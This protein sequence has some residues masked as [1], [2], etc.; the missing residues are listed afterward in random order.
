MNRKELIS[1]REYW[2]AKWQVDLFE[3]IKKYMTEKKLKRNSFAKE[4]NVT[5]GYISQVLNGDFDHRISKL[6]D[7][8]L[9]IGKAPIFKLEDIENIIEYEKRTGNNYVETMSRPIQ[10]INMYTYYSM[11]KTDFLPE[12]NQRS[13]INESVRQLVYHHE[14]QPIMG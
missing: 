7:L 5:K 12:T 6:I 13:I 14:K 11:E 4:L 1:R 2:L 10:Y 3:G 8:S 9:A